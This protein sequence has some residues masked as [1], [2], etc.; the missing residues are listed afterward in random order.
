LGNRHFETAL[1]LL[2]GWMMWRSELRATATGAAPCRDIPDE[3]IARAGPSLWPDK[4]VFLLRVA[5]DH[6]LGMALGIRLVV[7]V[8]EGARLE[9]KN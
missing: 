2:A 9:A 6:F 7:V 5:F 8:L 4:P 3:R 1:C